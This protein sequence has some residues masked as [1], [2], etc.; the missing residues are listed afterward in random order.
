M[1]NSSTAAKAP[2]CLHVC[3]MHQWSC[4]LGQ[5]VFPSLILLLPSLILVPVRL[6]LRK[7]K[8]CT[9]QP[10]LHFKKRDS[11]IKMLCIHP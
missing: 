10:I 11:K 1:I 6:F 8:I 2:V 3:L 7:Y 9:W 4:D 5:G